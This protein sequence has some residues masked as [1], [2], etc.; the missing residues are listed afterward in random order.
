MKSRGGGHV[1]EPGDHEGVGIFSNLF[2]TWLR[3]VLGGAEEDLKTFGYKLDN[4]YQNL[5][6]DDISW[7]IILWS[8]T[9]VRFHVLRHSQ[10]R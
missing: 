5:L 2:S 3:R 8:L 1:D 6:F 4:S 7:T 10:R 9:R